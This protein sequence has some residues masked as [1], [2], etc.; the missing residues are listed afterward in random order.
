MAQEF[1]D[2]L[3]RRKAEQAKLG[4]FNA[5]PTAAPGLQP[6][7]PMVQPES[8]FNAPAAVVLLHQVQ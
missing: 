1:I 5:Q 2:E 7:T 6:Q 8:V 4:G 3:N